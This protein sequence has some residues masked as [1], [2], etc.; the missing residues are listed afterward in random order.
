MGNGKRRAV[1]CVFCQERTFV[2]FNCTQLVNR[3]LRIQKT[4]LCPQHLA[5]LLVAGDHGRALVAGATLRLLA[6]AGGTIERRRI[7]VDAGALT[8]LPHRLLAALG[9]FDV[10]TRRLRGAAGFHLRRK[11]AKRRYGG[12]CGRSQH[13][14]QTGNA[15]PDHHA[16]RCR[17]RT[18]RGARRTENSSSARACC[19]RLRLLR[20]FSLCSLLCA[21]PAGPVR[22]L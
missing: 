19:R 6:G 17:Q 5:A 7:E 14:D 22:A 20:Y 15:P 4:A 9:L 13:G 12:C 1:P 8:R 10:E 3:A 11:R 18:V 21:A 2:T 16:L